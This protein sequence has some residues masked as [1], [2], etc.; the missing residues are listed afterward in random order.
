MFKKILGESMAKLKKIKYAIDNK[1]DHDD[2]AQAIDT[3]PESI[4]QKANE[5]VKMHDRLPMNR[6]E[7]LGAGI[8]HF[9]GF[10]AMP[11]MMKMM[12]TSAS[13]KA[14][15]AIC[16]VAK[17]S[18][19]PA[20]ITLNLAGGA[21][22]SA[23]WMPLD[24]GLNPLA[25][26]SKMGWGV[27]PSATREFANQAPFFA[28]SGFLNALKVAMPD[29]GALLSTNFV[30]IAVRSQD[31][32]SGN[33]FDITGLTKAA[34]LTGT[35]LANLGTNNT[36]T[37]NNTAPAYV[38]PPA[39]LV[40]GSYNDIVGALSVSGSLTT[41]ANRAPALFGTI[42]SLNTLQAQKFLGMN[43]GEQLEQLMV[44]RSKDNTNLVSNPNGAA[45][46]PLS[47]TGIATAWG[48][49]ANTSKA[50][51]DYVFA[52]LVYNALKGNAGSANL[53]IGGYDYH[54]GTRATGDTKD[55]DAGTVVGRILTSA[56]RLNK[57]V[58]IIV[59]SDGSVT[60]AESDIGGA[61]WGSDGGLRGSSFMIAMDPSGATV[62]SKFQ[63]G[64]YVAAQAAADNTLVGT[65]PERAAA[66][67]FVNY[68][69]F[70]KR[71]DLFEKN[72]PRVFSVADLDA[73][74]V[75]G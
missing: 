55:A 65:A 45:T 29:A 36:A 47:E 4:E 39:P 24:Q 70:A 43:Y 67:M 57:K 20:L 48:L 18:D 41:I 27:G 60:S 34:G 63:L 10:L 69:A 11:P 19:L 31:D 25:S 6:R 12:G 54:N 7:F 73:I 64:H 23:N 21:G 38:A 44:C 13:A 32:S 50:S 62:A 22:L 74:K 42:Q 71:I 51:R 52:T 15:G 2:K 40:V 72:L 35:L 68:L 75:F 53:T 59:T 14:A 16:D 58:F 1:Q 49:T 33:R 46:D 30:G 5:Y 9:G 17:A 26:Y 8:I 56:F 3:D 61:P 28:G 37:G 66:A